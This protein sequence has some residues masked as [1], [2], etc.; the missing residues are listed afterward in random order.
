MHSSIILAVLPFE[1]SQAEG[2]TIIRNFEQDLVYHLS[3]FQGL[4]I[5]SYFS[6]SH[7]SLNDEETLERFYVSHVVTGFFRRAKSRIVINVQLIELP[8]KRIIYDHRL[9]Y[10]EEHV[11]ELLDEA[12]V[13]VT[14]V[15]QNQ[16]N[17][18]ILSKS[19]QKPSIDLESYELMLMGNAFLKERTPDGDLKA[20]ALFEQ[21]LKKQPK[22][23]R[24]YA[25]ISCS[26]FNQWSCQT[27][28][29]WEISQSGAK[30]FALKAIDYDENDYQSLCILG[31]V[32]LFERDFDQA[33]FYL[34]K[35]LEMNSND[36]DILL[37]IAFCFIYLDAIDEALELYKRACLLNP[38]KE[39]KYLSVGTALVFE[40]GDYEK[41]L[42][43]GKQLEISNT[44]IDFPVYLA[45][46]SYYLGDEQKALEYWD[47]YLDR[48]EK[49]IY[50]HDKNRTQDPFSWQIKMNPYKGETKLANFHDYLRNNGYDANQKSKKPPNENVHSFILTNDRVT[51]IYGGESHN[52]RK[53][54]GLSDILKL[55]QNPGQDIH[56]MELMRTKNKSAQSVPLLDE[57][58]KK[59]YQDRII[60][61]QDDL[62]QAES[63]H[64]MA[65]VEKLSQEYEQLVE[66]LSKS[67]GLKG[68]SR[69]VGSTAEKARAAVTMRIRDCIKKIARENQ[70]LG[71]HLSN[72]IK[73]GLLCSYRPEISITWDNISP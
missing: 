50:F 23:A 30:K 24:A 36:P 67:L 19:Y 72:S 45:A 44:Y 22:Y 3:K 31:R 10:R 4:S 18:S 62:R 9:A 7:W 8:Q 46:M 54:K 57:R 37:E 68:E 27:W 56:C 66:H 63:S 49:H 34:R 59:S 39:E 38:L 40:K 6:T 35:S 73:T 2:N 70:A 69:R 48:F 25:G 5:L 14:N 55:L 52:F 47:I 65:Q 71:K 60:E 51:L 17:Q 41:A 43:L 32:L 12:V 1:G 26:Y 53:T 42:L 61:L 16:L 64:D 21:A 33:E 58:A 29:R 11:F 15:L 13:Q 28:D 20:R